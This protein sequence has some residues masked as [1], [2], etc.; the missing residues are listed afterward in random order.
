[1]IVPFVNSAVGLLFLTNGQFSQIS[2]NL[3]QFGGETLILTSL[4]VE[5]SLNF[6]IDGWL[7][8]L[9][10]LLDEVADVTVT[11]RSNLASKCK[12]LNNLKYMCYNSGLP[13]SGLLSKMYPVHLVVWLGEGRQHVNAV[14]GMSKWFGETGSNRMIVSSI[15]K[16]TGSWH[17]R[18]DE[19]LQMVK[20]VT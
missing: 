7:D 18:H 20:H 3:T 9:V 19:H 1:M 12:N 16:R 13:G 17:W 8:K 14:I 11:K 2:L 10:S 6:L 4:N 15:P 5:V